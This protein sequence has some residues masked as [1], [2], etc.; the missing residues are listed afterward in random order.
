MIT[1]ADIRS[2]PTTGEDLELLFR[3]GAISSS[4]LAVENRLQSDMAYQLTAVL[5]SLSFV[6]IMGGCNSA[7]IPT[8]TELI[9]NTDQIAT[10][11]TGDV[12]A[13]PAHITLTPLDECVLALPAAILDRDTPIGDVIAG[14][15]EM[16]INIPDGDD[17]IYIRLMPNMS[18]T[19]RR[20]CQALIVG[21]GGRACRFKVHSA[22]ESGT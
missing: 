18:V 12:F 5:I 7:D 15:D 8:T 16:G 17:K 4:S 9:V 2:S 1:L 10:Q 19:V 3:I 11:S 6:A 22:N 20:S 21:E 13:W 14:D